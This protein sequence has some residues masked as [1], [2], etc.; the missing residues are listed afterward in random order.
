MA[1]LEVSAPYVPKLLVGLGN[2]GQKYDR[3]R[4]NVGFEVIDHLAAQWSVKL[5]ENKRFHGNFGEFRLGTGDRLILLKPT[6]YMN[7]SGQSVR[8]VLDW[9]KLTAADVLVIYDDMDLPI[10]K[11]RLRLSG[12]AGGHNGMK[13]IISHLGTQDFPRLRLGISRADQAAGQPGGAVVG[14][15]LGKFAPDERKV[16]NASI[17]FAGEA[18][19][20]S[21]R[22]GIERAMNLYNGRQVEV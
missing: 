8:A 1:T 9:Y 14:H 11:L 2:P 13:S 22:K 19:E 18:V 20:F 5:T 7:R 17:D 3:T 15:V 4:H 16:V 10:G 12:S 21:L 6:T